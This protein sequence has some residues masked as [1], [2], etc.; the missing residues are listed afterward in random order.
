MSGT[1][2]VSEHLFCSPKWSGAPLSV[3]MILARMPERQ[4]NSM[5]A[6]SSLAPSKLP[7]SVTWRGA[8][9]RWLEISP[10]FQLGGRMAHSFLPLYILS[11]ISH[12]LP[13][14]LS[15]PVVPTPCYSA[16]HLCDRSLLISCLSFIPSITTDKFFWSTSHFPA[17]KF[18][19]TLAFIFQIKSMQLCLS[20]KAA[21]AMFSSQSRVCALPL[22]FPLCLFLHLCLSFLC[23]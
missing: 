13:S 3:T 15:L 1:H 18:P 17:Q 16:R 23:T 10:Y 20:L 22:C 7:P 12:F 5:K 6:S 8:P 21:P 14:V 2:P 9:P 11:S 4:H 19:W